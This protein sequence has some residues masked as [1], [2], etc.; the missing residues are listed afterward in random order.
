MVEEAEPLHLAFVR[1]QQADREDDRHSS[2]GQPDRQQE[3]LKDGL[4]VQFL[5]AADQLDQHI[6]N[7]P[8]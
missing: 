5:P 4:K 1:R 3:Q 8:S 7:D 2:D 6:K